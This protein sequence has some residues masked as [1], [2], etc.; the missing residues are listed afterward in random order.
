MYDIN[1]NKEH[2]P[3]QEENKILTKLQDLNE[4]VF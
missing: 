1:K 2:Q 3:I 4:G